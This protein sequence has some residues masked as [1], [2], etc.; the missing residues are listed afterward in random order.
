MVG[1]SAPSR[2]LARPLTRRRRAQSRDVRFSSMTGSLRFRLP[3][4]FLLGI[5][6]AGVATAA[7]SVQLFSGYTR[8]R[9]YDEL[10]REARG[11]ARLYGSAA[12]RAA[13][14]GTPAPDFAPEA[15]ELATGDRLYYVGAPAFPG[16]D[17]DLQK[18]P[19]SAVPAEVLAAQ[20]PLE[21]EFRPPGERRSFLAASQPLRLER[22][23]PPL[24]AIV[25]AKAQDVVRDQ[26]A[27]LIGRLAA[28][29]AIGGLLAW[30]LGLWLSQR[31]S[32]PVDAL[33]R[34]SDEIASGNYAVQVP[35]GRG[36]R[37]VSERFNEMAARLAATE[38]RERQF[39]MS[40]SHELRTPL[41]AIKGH[42]DALRDGLVDDP[43][44]IRASL[45]VVA[46]EATRL[47]RLVGDVLDLAKLRAHRF[48]VQTEEVDL[49]RLVEQAYGSFGDEARRRE[50]HYA[51]EGVDLAPTIITDGDRVL[52]VITNLLKNAFRWTPDGGSIGLGLESANG[53]V[54]VDVTDTGPGISSEN[55]ERIFSPFVSHDTQGTG[56]GLPIARELAGALGGRI[57]LESEVGRG[58][59]FRLVLPLRGA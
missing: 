45:D 35:V 10:G 15:L 41:T 3:A 19:E 39:L 22:D 34:A 11:I 13:E 24:G 30:L 14:E 48:T 37:E 44:L 18:L 58:S 59:R 32:G 6:I 2:P 8:N 20:A 21:F 47:E 27:P 54:R 57:E 36:G 42:V 56:L 5:V 28:A 52:Q 49:G 29:I 38:E 43:E 50:I 1:Q 26:W 55:A 46:S 33:A 40:V 12:L 7:I 23:G 4:L 31:I 16:Q 53:V 25:V 17:D 51:L 9:S